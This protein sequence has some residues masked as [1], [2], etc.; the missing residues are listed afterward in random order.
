[1]RRFTFHIFLFL[2]PV[3]GLLMIIPISKR[4]HFISMKDDCFNHGIWLHDRIFENPLPID[5]AFIGSS[6]T[7][8]AI[9]EL[10]LDSLL[11]KQQVHSANLGYCRLGRNMD[12]AILKELLKNKKPKVVVM[13][14]RETESR[15]S[16]PAFPYIASQKDVILPALLFNRDIAKDAFTTFAYKTELIQDHF[17]S[18]QPAPPIDLNPSGYVTHL[19]T[20]KKELLQEFLLKR[21]Q[22]EKKASGPEH[23]FY[24]AYPKNYLDKIVSV[25]EEN[26]IQLMFLYLPGYGTT[27]TYAVPE[28]A[29]YYQEHG[30]LLIPPAAILQTTSNWFDENHL[31]KVG[32]E[33]LCIWLG[34][35]LKGL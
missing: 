20:A 23:D 19:D 32:S 28:E 29:V 10:Q 3:L 18:S 12:Y 2:L 8:N 27:K 5:I 11:N 21:G 31:N 17:F 4:Q 1:M 24:N 33:K 7:I 13:E 9:N 16:H 15:Y 14:V 26:K 34:E 6:H 22:P 30:K 25:C 35:E